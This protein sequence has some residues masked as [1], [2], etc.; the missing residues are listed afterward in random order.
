M[1]EDL[2]SYQ[3]KDKVAIIT[4][5]RTDKL[6]AFD[7]IMVEK[8]HDIWHKFEQDKEARVA[9]ITGKGRAFSVGMDFNDQTKVSPAVPGIGVKVTKP[10]ISAINGHCIGLGLVLALK[11]DIRISTEKASFVYPEAKIGYTGGMGT[12][13]AKYIPL[14]IAME[15]LLSG[16]GITSQRAHQ[17]GLVNHVVSEDKLIDKAMEIAKGIAN[18]APLVVRALKKLAYDRD[19]I[20]TA[21]ASNRI[22]SEIENSPD[23]QEGLQA[24]LDKREPDFSG[25]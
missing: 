12:L 6:N 17:I 23:R 10:I 16:E 11:S 25:K 14:G 4:L 20:E 22:I 8:L 7:S 24:F 15:M 21:G 18:N 13:I 1:S 2:I 9:I 19:I 5:K 3:L